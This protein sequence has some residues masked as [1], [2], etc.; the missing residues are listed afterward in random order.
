M[1]ISTKAD[2]RS[3]FAKREELATEQTQTVWA[4][5]YDLLRSLKLTTFFGNP[6]STE[7]TFLK[8]LR[9]ERKFPS[10]AALQQQ[11]ERDVEAARGLPE[12][13]N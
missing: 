11:I 13:K 4:A 6:G 5:T 9:E 12:N 2:T 10:A 3:S 7:L 8:K 1:A